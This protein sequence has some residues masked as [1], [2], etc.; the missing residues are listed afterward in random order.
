MIDVFRRFADKHVCMNGAQINLTVLKQLHEMGYTYL[1]STQA[2][3]HCNNEINEALLW[4]E[5]FMSNL[6]NQYPS[7]IVNVVRTFIRIS[8]LF[9][10]PRKFINMYF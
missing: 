6:N 4:I 3:M 1:I 10:F 8:V 2:L 5:K 9:I 7:Y